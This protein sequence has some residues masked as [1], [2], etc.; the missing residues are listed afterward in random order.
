MADPTY[1]LHLGNGVYLDSNGNIT[2]GAEPA[3]IIYQAEFKL[4]IDP[5]KAADALKS[6]ADTLSGVD[7]SEKVI[8]D[9]KEV[10]E[11][12]FKVS[13]TVDADALLGMLSVIGKIAGTI[14]PVI[15]VAS[16]AIDL[17]RV[18]KIFGGDEPTAF[19]RLVEKR[20]A[21]VDAQFAAIAQSDQG[22]NMIQGRVATSSMFADATD[23]VNRLNNTNPNPAELEALSINL[24]GSIN[25]NRTGLLTLLD[26]QSWLT[27]FNPSKHSQIWGLMQH[28]LFFMPGSAVAAPV[29]ARLPA[30]PSNQFDHRLMV[31]LASYAAESFLAALRALAPEYRST[32]DFRETL[33]IFAEDIAKLAEKMRSDVL[34]R[35]IYT[36]EDFRVLL[37]PFDVIHD[38]FSHEPVAMSPSCS[39]FP[40]GALDLR[41]HDNFFFDSFIATLVR[42]EFFGWPTTTKKAMMD[43]R[44][45]P[46]ARLVVSHG[47]NNE[48]NGFHITNPEECA[49]AANAQSE[50][51]YADLLAVSG[52]PQLLQLAMLLRHETTDPNVSQTVQILNPII[53]RRSLASKT[54]T[55]ESEPVPFAPKITASALREPQRCS[56]TV[57]IWT[58]PLKRILPV[59]YVVRLRTLKS[60]WGTPKRWR[61]PVY[62]AFQ[63]LHYEPD[64]NDPNFLEL[65]FDER[66]A[67][68][69]ATKPLTEGHSPQGESVSRQDTVTLKA[70]TFDWWIPVRPPYSLTVPLDTTAKSLRGMG[71]PTTVTDTGQPRTA[72]DF[73]PDPSARF[74][75]SE[76][77]QL[78]GSVPQLAFLDGS[79]N[80]EGEHREPKETDVTLTYHL[81]WDG[82]R[83]HIKLEADPTDRNYVVYIVIEEKLQGGKG[84][85]LHTA[86]PVPMNGQLTYV[87][88]SFFDAEHAA[89][90]KAAKTAAEFNRRFSQSATVGP[91][92]PVVGSLRP[93]DLASITGLSKVLALAKRNEPELLREVEA[94]LEDSPGTDCVLEAGS[95]LKGSKRVKSQRRVAERCGSRDSEGRFVRRS[96]SRKKGAKPEEG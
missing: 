52:Y 95:R 46:P 70:H 47:P 51:D 77:I 31:P 85:I 55:I 17:A 5:K 80:W 59:E 71:R 4:P 7:K 32:G 39:R 14:A 8:K 53:A 35:T 57:E 19:Q 62:S 40:V 89:I 86:M 56:A 15:L 18:F 24:H 72:A 25:E 27:L 23:Y 44:W 92:D 75:T 69:D 63:F 10:Y 6:V 83:M 22:M 66:D 13:E 37:D 26:L 96:L 76:R 21:D 28:Q 88:Q 67:A 54:V 48:F 60:I 43:F 79:Q 90:D 16:F 30:G 91:S 34:A 49:A 38:A 29:P 58:Q 93:G 87:P 33:H 74:A 61:E 3:P 84:N 68:V 41:Y 42:L 20:F 12:L 1:A 2:H 11:F 50:S 82:D 9:I 64:L 78:D 45:L 65:I 36:A 81:T 94:S 73:R